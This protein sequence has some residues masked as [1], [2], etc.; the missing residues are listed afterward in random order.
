MSP[1]SPGRA[2]PSCRETETDPL[3]ERPAR[4]QFPEL[5]SRLPGDLAGSPAVG[6]APFPPAHRG[7]EHGGRR[8]RLAGASGPGGRRALPVALSVGNLTQR[9]RASRA[10]AGSGGV[11]GRTAASP[12][13]GGGG[14]EGR[15][16][17]G[18]N[19]RYSQ[20]RAARLRGTPG[21]SGAPGGGGWVVAAPGPGRG[22]ATA[23]AQPSGPA[24]GRRA[25]SGRPA[26]SRP[27]AP[28][29]PRGRSGAPGRL[30][31][32]PRRS[33]GRAGGRGAAAAGRGWRA[34]LTAGRGAR[35]ASEAAACGGGVGAGRGE[36]ER[37][38]KTQNKHYRGGRRAPCAA[39]PRAGPPH[40]GANPWGGRP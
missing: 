19:K 32:A 5:G 31:G 36:R 40:R 13:R 6:A 4:S 16:G 38:R 10:G 34:E 37:K 23:A 3:H 18:P 2:T 27:A 26:R 35:Q 1:P 11:R 29:S 20:R 8:S 24:A 17:R 21:I 22:P 9:P 39:Q 14:G 25:G 30:D 15:G 28:P 12:V 33:A 7:A